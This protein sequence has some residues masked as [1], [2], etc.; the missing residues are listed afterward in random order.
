MK[1]LTER[2]GKIGYC[3]L[4]VIFACSMTILKTWQLDNDIWFILNCGRYV[5][6]SG[7][8]PHTEF[9]TMHEGLHYV[10]EQ[11]LTAVIFWKVYSNFGVDGFLTFI[12]LIGF[13]LVFVYYRLCLYVSEGNKKI[14]ALL[15]F[16]VGGGIVFNF[17]VTR[18]QIL[19]TLILLTEIFLLE[20][21][22]REKKI[23]TLCILPVLAIPFI[24]MHAAL[25][26][27]M[28]IVVLPFIA[29]SLMQK[30]IPAKNFEISLLP[31][32]VTVIG[33]FIAGFINPYGLEAITFLFV[34]YNPEIH[35]VIDEL[36]PTSVG[37]FVGKVF[38]VFETLVIIAYTKKSL[39][40]RYFFMTFG[41]MILGFVAIRNIFLF[42]MLATFPLAYAAKDWHPF[43]NFF[44]MKYKLFIPLFAGCIAEFYFLYSK[45]QTSEVVMHLPMKIIFCTSIF[46][47]L[48]FVFFYKREGKLFSEE[49]SILRHKPLIA[50][51]VFQMIF[52]MSMY[53][54]KHPAPQYEIYKPALDYLLENNR[55]EDIILWTDCNSGG[56]A[57][58]RGVKTYLDA[59]PEVF[60]ISN[61]HKKDII[62]EYFDFA[63]GNLDYK[64]FFSRYN[65]THIFITSNDT[66]PYLHLSEDE[67]YEMLF[68]CEFPYGQ[69]H[70]K[71][72]KPVKKDD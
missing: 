14:S 3:G 46:L 24:N 47:L 12:W 39:P 17:I 55:A 52:F 53:H 41:I 40:P 43:D 20:K 69:G 30:V 64:E 54:Y 59:R 25:F 51:A 15:A 1:I 72:F 35:G 57:E 44:S 10:M 4:I 11:W 28:I 26:P 71:I 66:I 6:E 68:E 42:L 8:I 62:Q 31:L 60:A 45:A 63:R 37:N 61:N 36:Q 2:I 27:M 32:I 23:W 7:T 58:F 65:F 22:V 38:F 18:P 5:T 49:I 33:I 16:A 21:F 19:S 34:S 29:E 67:D 56:Y 9:A 13:I 50:L 48:C 70:G